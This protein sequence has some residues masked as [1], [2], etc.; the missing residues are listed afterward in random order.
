ML[1]T[2]NEVL[3][4][5]KKNKYAVGLFNTVN[6]EMLRGVIGAAEEAKSPV[7]IGTA[8]VLL[9]VN[10]LKDLSAMLVDAAKRASVPVV[11]HFDHGLTEDRIF[12]AMD[13]GFTS[14]MYDCS[15]LDY[16]EN[17]IA[18]AKMVEQA[19]KRGITVEGEL[20]HVGANESDYDTSIYTEPDAAKDLPKAPELML[21][22]SQ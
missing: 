11:L 1:V 3:K 9:P 15:T 13:R 20:G 10:D 7:I 22:R 16:E 8:E 12:E 19:H 6:L 5:A 21:L 2:L 4:D 17:K 14:I 18:V